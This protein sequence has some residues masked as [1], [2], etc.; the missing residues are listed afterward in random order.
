M[1]RN[2]IFFKEDIN[3]IYKVKKILNI[4]K[5]N[6][7]LLYAPTWRDDK[8]PKDYNINFNEV[9]NILQEEF[10]GKWSIVLRMHHM[11]NGILKRSNIIDASNYGDMQ[12]LLYTTDVL[13]TDYSSCIWD[14]SFTY[15]P[16]FL[17]AT[18]LKSYKKDRDFYIDIHKWPFP[19]AESNNQL[20]NNIKSFDKYKYIKDV[21]KHHKELGSFEN[22][23]ATEYVSE[24]VV[25]MCTKI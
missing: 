20:I 25:K 17:Y 22:G 19:L 24:F 10:G 15:R 12:E 16:C 9:S 4:P 6:K 11:I 7:V 8:L 3:I 13:I 5:E 18:D 21:K 14:F 2:D 1:P 23:Y